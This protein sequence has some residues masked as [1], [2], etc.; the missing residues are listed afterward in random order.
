MLWILQVESMTVKCERTKNM[1]SVAKLQWLFCQPWK[2]YMSLQGHLIVNHCL[3]CLYQHYHNSLIHTHIVMLCVTL[4]QTLGKKLN[5]LRMTFKSYSSKQRQ[6]WST[7]EATVLRLFCMWYTYRNKMLHSKYV[8][9]IQLVFCRPTHRPLSTWL[10]IWIFASSS[11]LSCRI[12][13]YLGK[14]INLTLCYLYCCTV[15]FEDSL[16]IIHQQMH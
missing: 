3:S 13:S 15:H 16:S 10:R 12:W 1:N 5:S 7:I 2:C 9:Q 8:L 11:T 6:I 14:L 4:C